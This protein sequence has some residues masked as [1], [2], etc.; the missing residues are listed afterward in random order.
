MKLPQLQE[1]IFTFSSETLR[2]LV[3]I[4]CMTFM[5][6]MS[7]STNSSNDKDEQAHLQLRARNRVLPQ[8]NMLI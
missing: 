4:V 1:T 8:F 7:K 6:H 3:I 2:V 5:S